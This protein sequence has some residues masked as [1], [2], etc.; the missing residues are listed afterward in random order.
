M[1]ATSINTGIRSITG[2]NTG[3]QVGESLAKLLSGISFIHSHIGDFR[4]DNNSDKWAYVVSGCLICKTEKRSNLITDEDD[5]IP[6]QPDTYITDILSNLSVAF[7]ANDKFF[8]FGGK[9]S[10][11]LLKQYLSSVNMDADTIRKICDVYNGIN[12]NKLLP[13]PFK[14]HEICYIDTEHEGKQ[15]KGQAIIESVKWCF[16]S[17]GKLVQSVNFKFLKSL[18]DD[19]KRR[20]SL[21]IS[22][23]GVNFTVPSIEITLRTADIHREL[24]KISDFGFIKPIVVKEKD[25]QIALDNVG[26]YLINGDNAVMIGKWIRNDLRMYSSTNR[27][28]DNLDSYKLLRD[29][30]GFIGKHLK[31]IA[32]YRAYES[33]VVNF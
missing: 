17:S 8:S 32:A 33:K 9:S 20:I 10:L 11:N 25:I 7:S 19:Y 31:Y 27:Y 30:S 14:L 12:K 18:G 15:Y 6:N 28:I 3:I 1:F 5:L 29:S 23:Y 26:M 21:P 24:I 22:S 16:N 2:P 13:M 4:K